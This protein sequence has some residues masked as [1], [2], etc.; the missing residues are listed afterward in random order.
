MWVMPVVGTAF[1]LVGGAMLFAAVRGARG[2]GIPPTEV[3]IERGTRL[4]PGDTVRLLL[5]QPGAADIESLR[6]VLRCERVYRRAVRATSNSTVEDRD[7]IWE[8]ELLDIRDRRVPAGS[9]LQ[10]EAAFTLPPDA[11]PTGPASPDGRIRWQLEARGEM[12]WLRAT[13]RVFVVRV[14]GGAEAFGTADEHRRGHGGSD[15]PTGEASNATS[16][17]GPRRP[18][19]PRVSAPGGCF[20]LGLGFLVGGLLGVLQRRRV[21]RAR[22][23][24][25]G[26]S[27]AASS[28]WSDWRLSWF[29]SCRWC[30]R[31]VA[32]IAADPGLTDVLLRG[33]TTRMPPPLVSS[34]RPGTRLTPS[35]LVLVVANLLPLYGV[36][37]LHWQV[38]PVIL[39]FWLENIVIGG[40]N[41]LKM[42]LV[43]SPEESSAA[44]KVVM[45][46]SF[47]FHYG[48]FASG[49]GVFVLMLFG[50]FAGPDGNH[51]DL[52]YIWH[53]VA[54]LGIAWPLLAL[55]VSHAA[56]FL[57]NYIGNA[58]YKTANLRD[59][60]MLPYG[61]VLVLH[62]VLIFGGLAVLAL[63][64]P[65]VALAISSS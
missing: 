61:R 2:A 34:Q 18:T 31:V 63:G 6:L 51:T 58:E 62:A 19:A 29:L 39:L 43:S 14:G 28:P 52:P 1:A 59:L 9:V 54:G 38:F 60:M 8:Q 17:A 26:P 10:R 15:S 41:A 37:F 64:T 7:S 13:Y 5:R 40:F 53:T 56:S 45:T 11:R 50:P 42:L 3:C 4:R 25:H 47:W 27:A 49:H 65:T 35:V 36:L 57:L 55:V 20:V 48:G 32:G 12:G 16:P 24:L 23:P 46:A 22:Q 30:R 44:R 21:L 33:G